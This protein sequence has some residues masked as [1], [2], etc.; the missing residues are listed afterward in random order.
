MRAFVSR[1]SQLSSIIWRCEKSYCWNTVKV[2]PNLVLTLLKKNHQLKKTKHFGGCLT[3]HTT[4]SYCSFSYIPLLD[5]DP[6]RES[7][8]FVFENWKVDVISNCNWRWVSTS[9]IG[10]K[11]LKFHKMKLLV[12]FLVIIL[13]FLEKYFR[14]KDTL[15]SQ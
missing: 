8:I 14:C 10:Q 6:T 9:E 13:V 7:L 4:S 12:K 2:P 3:Q 5:F 15:G 1:S 11:Y